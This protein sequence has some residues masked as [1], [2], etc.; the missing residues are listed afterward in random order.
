MRELDSSKRF[1][2]WIRGTHLFKVHP[3]AKSPVFSHANS[4]Y[5]GRA[6]IRCSQAQV[7]AC[8][9]F[10]EYQ[11]NHT[12]A[13]SLIHYSL[14]AYNFGLDV[15]TGIFTVLVIYSFILF[16]DSNGA[17]VGLAIT[18]ILMLTGILARG[19]KL[20]AD[21]ETMMVAVE[22]LFE[23]TE[24]ESEDESGQSPPTSWPSSGKIRFDSVT[25]R[26]SENSPPVLNNV[27]FTIEAGTKVISLPE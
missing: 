12:R 26:Y 13:A 6:T 21:I 1:M 3:L 15:V 9:E 7:L 16:G 17:S 22:R 24:L 4:S 10:D 8:K 14:V 18:Q 2:I 27:D 20:T 5:T 23:Y 11:D 19:I 25:L